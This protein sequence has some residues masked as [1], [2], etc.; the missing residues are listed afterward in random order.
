MAIK[1]RQALRSALTLIKNPDNFAASVELAEALAGW[2]LRR[3]RYQ[4]TL[5]TLPPEAAAHLREITERP[6]DVDELLRLPENT[7]GHRYGRFILDNGIDPDAPQ[8]AFPP[9]AQ[10]FADDWLLLRFQRTHDIHHLLLGWGFDFPAELGLQIFTVRNFLEPYGLFAIGSIP[11]AM[12][13]TGEPRRVLREV[14]KGWTLGGRLPDLFWMPLE[15]MFPMDFD[16]V[17]AKLGI[18]GG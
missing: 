17:R 18:A 6:V 4:R 3:L 9:M 7:L 2:S 10:A 1:V 8:R 5:A 14:A 12:V 15:D 13:T 11:V 16:E